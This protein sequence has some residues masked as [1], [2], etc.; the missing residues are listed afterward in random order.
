MPGGDVI[1]PTVRTP[2]LGSRAPLWKSKWLLVSAAKAVRS[3]S[4][5]ARRRA[6]TPGARGS[7]SIS[8]CRLS[9][10]KV[11]LPELRVNYSVFPEAIV[12]NREHLW[13]STLMRLHFSL[14]PS[15]PYYSTS[16]QFSW[17]YSS[18]RTNGIAAV[19]WRG[20]WLS[21]RC[22]REASLEEINALCGVEWREMPA[23]RDS[24]N[25]FCVH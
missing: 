23:L 4:L 25:V 22:A 17:M 18:E 6:L 3:C 1:S 10:N 15:P 5:S 19:Q 8:L 24:A 20:S 14:F 11:T 16:I 12:F 7:Y 9:A 21:I 13:G 2:T